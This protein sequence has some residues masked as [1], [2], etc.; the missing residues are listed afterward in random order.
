[1]FARR[2]LEVARAHAG[3]TRANIPAARTM[4]RC[5]DLS[6]F[7]S[8]LQGLIFI[9]KSFKPQRQHVDSSF[10]S[11]QVYTMFLL[12]GTSAMYTTLFGLWA[13]YNVYRDPYRTQSFWPAFKASHHQMTV[14]CCCCCCCCGGG[15]VV[16]C[17]ACTCAPGIVASI[18][19]HSNL[20][21]ASRHRAIA[22]VVRA[23][24]D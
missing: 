24:L 14:R 8:C 3:S 16:G 9:C 1:V 11:L 20:L 6:F 18:Y 5:C 10:D 15:V 2:S 22:G 17:R 23:R 13:A 19:S 21:H 12:Y 4:C 7:C